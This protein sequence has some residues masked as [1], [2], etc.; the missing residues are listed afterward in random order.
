[1]TVT[2]ARSI[3]EAIDLA[4][5]WK[6]EGKYDWFRGQT[7]SW[8]VVA[9][10]LRQSPTEQNATQEKVDRFFNWVNA[11]K[12][13]QYLA[14]DE[15][16]IVAVAQH[17]GLPSPFIDFTTNPR[18]AGFFAT[19]GEDLE[20]GQECYICCLNTER[21]KDFWSSICSTNSEIPMLEFLTPE[22]DN[23]WR[24][25]A[26]E[27]V[28]LYCP[29]L[30]FENFY[31]LDRIAFPYGA[32][33]EIPIE[34]IY[35][36][37]KSHLEILLDQFFAKEL[38]L[39]GGK[40]LINMVQNTGMAMAVYEPPDLNALGNYFYP[41]RVTL[42]DSWNE[43]N[44]KIWLTPNKEVW[45]ETESKEHWEFECSIREL[46]TEFRN[47]IEKNLHLRFSSVSNCREKLVDWSFRFDDDVSQK[48]E[49]ESIMQQTARRIFDGM[50]R[51]PYL[52]NEVIKSISMGIALTLAW[53][54]SGQSR[55]E[56]NWRKIFSHLI[57]NDMEVE[58]GTWAG[59]SSRG[60]V[61]REKLFA[62]LRDDVTNLIKP[63]Y[64]S[65]F[66]SGIVP[67]IQFIID[68]SKIYD[69]EKFK[70]IFVEEIIPTQSIIRDLNFPVYFTPAGLEIFGLP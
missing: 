48:S 17:Y 53:F 14:D 65:Q 29:I 10:F 67:I 61:S 52:D 69:F 68:P 11:T 40:R 63:S 31:R 13:L 54:Q 36:A 7:Q 32:R 39:E 35:P 70:S 44:L 3:K 22:V 21:L 9:S 4:L 38:A 8:K 37:R 64:R 47:R 57:P 55:H 5:K 23:L 46:P 20:I 16:K 25:E 62:C 30:Y 41:E 51:L 45:A 42:V 6:A 19:D 27:G 58:F 34:K 12:G 56:A 2:N 43:D 59:A 28:F 66:L 26:Q 1:M 50:R 49:K 18:I 33:Y 60:Y 24:L 15:D